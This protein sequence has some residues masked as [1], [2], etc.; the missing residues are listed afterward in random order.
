MIPDSQL[1]NTY[2]ILDVADMSSVDFS[3]INETSKHTVRYNLD[4]TKFIV[5]YSGSLPSFLIGR[6]TY[7]HEEIN[8][9]ISDSA[10]GWYDPEEI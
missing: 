4:N 6:T 10:N 5:K 7:T 8:S 2:V 3:A 9:H 1:Q